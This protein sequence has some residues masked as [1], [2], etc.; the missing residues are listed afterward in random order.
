MIYGVNRSIFD[1]IDELRV[2][3]EF[4]GKSVFCISGGSLSSMGTTK[5]KKVIIP[6][7]IRDIGARTFMYHYNL[8]EVVFESSIPPI[9]FGTDAFIGSESAVF[10]VPDGAK[11]LYVQ[12]MPARLSNR[13]FEISE[14]TDFMIDNE[15]ALVGY[16]GDKHDI[17]IPA[18]V[19]AIS[20]YAFGYNQAIKSV[21][22]PS[23][24][25]EI[26]DNSFYQ[27]LNLH[28]IIFEEN[29]SLSLIG[30][31][32]FYDCNL[33]SLNLPLLVT[34]IGSNAFAYNKQLDSVTLNEGLLRIG[35]Y[36]F[37]GCSTL[38]SI[39]LPSSLEL[40]G[41]DAFNN[42][43]LYSR[44]KDT[45]AVYLGGWLLTHLGGDMQY[46]IQTD[47]LGIAS[48][49]FAYNYFPT[50]VVVNAEMQWVGEYVFGVLVD[51]ITFLGEIPPK[52]ESGSFVNINVIIFVPEGSLA[53]YQE[54]IGDS[55]DIRI[56]E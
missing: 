21:F 31:S 39:D 28:T 54:A 4:N 1:L 20:S 46:E 51:R 25:T 55:F 3:S 45:G 17:V 7:S 35:N 43:K 23:T 41:Y 10:F 9:N 26:R 12:A 14:R 32:A 52:F 16:L 53:A 49:A 56:I 30:V 34:K 8:R 18:G 19:T 6:A 29:S 11:D 48:D 27:A 5:I 15:G 13:I 44:G 40:I 33:T 2:P 37:S 47:T 50:I 36:A 22:I 42:T 38:A 24:V